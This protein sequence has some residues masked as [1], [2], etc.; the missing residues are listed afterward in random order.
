[1]LNYVTK[2]TR[3]S[4]VFLALALLLVGSPAMAHPQSPPFTESFAVAAAPAAAA[5]SINLC[6]R[7]GQVT[8]P[9]GAVIPIWGYVNAVNAANVP[10][11]CDDLLI[12]SLPP[13]LPGPV[14]RVDQGDTVTITLYNELPVA[15][16]IIFPGQNA[17]WSPTASGD[18]P[19]VF[20]EEAAANGG[21]ATY[22]FTAHAPGTYLY[23]S[24][25][26]NQPQ[27]PMG[28]YGA[29]IVDPATAGQAYSH[30]STAYDVEEVLVLSEIDPALNADVS[31]NPTSFSYDLLNYLPTYW[32]LNGRAYG[33]GTTNPDVLDPDDASTA[34]PY[35]SAINLDL[36]SGQSRLLLRYLNASGT[37]HTMTLLGN[38]QRVIARDADE[39]DFVG[40]ST[41][42]YDAVAETVPSGQTTDAIV[43][44]TTAGEY[45]LFNRQLHITNGDAASSLHY[46]PGGGMMTIVMATGTGGPPPVSTEADL[47]VTKTDEPDPV[48]AG[49][50]V[51]YTVT[52]TNNGPDQADNV[53]LSDP[54]PGG[55]TLVSATP[56]QGSCDTTVSCNLGNIAGGGNAS[57]TIVVTTGGAGLLSN[58][59]N[60]ESDTSDPVSGNN[61]A[62]TET[63]VN[64]VVVA[65]MHLGGL[66][67][68]RSG[69]ANFN[70][71]ATIT[72]HNGSHAPVANATVSG[73]WT[74]TFGNGFGGSGANPTCMTN[75]AGQC[76]VQRNALQALTFMVNSVTHAT[77]TYQVPHDVPT[78]VTQ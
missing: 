6:A 77:L 18:Q 68:A 31:A 16:S 59:V 47:S 19:G 60:V 3:F 35:S 14:I 27:V 61:S 23:E 46:A 12:A 37:H 55:V 43:T 17:D 10:I 65:S 78:G 20:T 39:L 5:V 74:G 26:A 72:I 41:Q 75:A 21:T 29:L 76:T 9:D 25:T 36:D 67:Q 52:V 11:A 8:M 66:T 15:T 28:L 33:P 73:S 69:F 24:G 40:L 64:P 2:L 4:P 54:L 22:T 30:P 42:Q 51:T 48:T 32:L 7:E 58:T 62:T 49:N 71:F 50:N 34:Q 13:Q 70:H 44:F 53:I 38:Y 57:V 1:M 63:T 56:S 45:A